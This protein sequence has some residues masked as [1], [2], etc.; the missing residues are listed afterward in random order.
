M[1]QN[2]TMTFR[3]FCLTLLQYYRNY[4]NNV[5]MRKIFTLLLLVF[6]ATPP[7]LHAADS[8]FKQ[9]SIYKRV[10]QNLALQNVDPTNPSSDYDINDTDGSIT[11]FLRMLFY[12]QEF[13]TDEGYYIWTTDYGLDQL[14]ANKLY[15]NNPELYG[16]YLRL[17]KGIDL[18]NT[19]LEN[20][21]T[22]TDSK[23]VQQRAEVRAMRALYFSYAMD[24][25]G[26]PPLTTSTTEVGKQVGRS[27][28]FDFI[29]NELKNVE[30]SVPAAKAYTSSDAN[31]GHVNQGVVWMLL[32]RL[33]LNAGVYT[34]TPHWA[35]AATYAKKVI[36]SGAYQLYTTATNGWSAYQ[37]LF[38]GDN[39][40]TKATQEMILPIY[41]QSKAVESWGAS[42][43]VAGPCQS[44][45]II[46]PDK[47]TK[48][49]GLSNGAWECVTAREPLVKRFFPDGKVPNVHACEM[50]TK[51]GDDRAIIEHSNGGY[52]YESDSQ[53]APYMVKYINFKTDGSAGSDKNFIDTDIPLMRYAEALMTYA[54][55]EFR[56]GNTQ[57]ALKYV[58]EIRT[59]ANA[60]T[61]TSLTLN[62]LYDE[63]SREFFYESRR[64]TDMIRFAKFAKAEFRNVF[65][66]P[67]KVQ[68]EQN[69]VQNAGYLAPT[70]KVAFH[71]PSFLNETITLDSITALRFSWTSVG[72]GAYDYVVKIDGSPN[73]SIELKK[74]TDTTLT[75]SARDLQR[76]IWSKY[77]Y[78]PAPKQIDQKVY[79]SALYNGKV[80]S[81]DSLTLHLVRSS[82]IDKH[83][84]FIAGKGIG[85]SKNDTSVK[86]VGSSSYPIIGTTEL[87]SDKRQNYMYFEQ[88]D[89]FKL[90]VPGHKDLQIRSLD[91]GIS[92]YYYNT[93]PWSHGMIYPCF[94]ISTAGWYKIGKLNEDTMTIAQVDDEVKEK[95]FK[96][97]KLTAGSQVYELKPMSNRTHETVYFR[98]VAIDKKTRVDIDA[99]TVALAHGVEL[100]PGTY[101]VFVNKQSLL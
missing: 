78:S 46:N 42:F 100:E 67:E 58:N 71:T 1:E 38:M 14:D 77:T 57:E 45:L 44:D 22:P 50:P 24:L 7:L 29:V 26:N 73:K 61:L 5:F 98:Q 6:L 36:D 101:D 21:S 53:N 94:T 18:C 76:A 64:R 99:D 8:G 13:T 62:D 59:R 84:W 33:Y 56:L 41:L 83:V 37:Q 88:G 65:P 10:Y 75:V 9:D 54:E 20:T 31:Y 32:A 28:L 52:N 11:G 27:A 87:Y 19:F 97:I 86:G 15:T 79:V 69:L 4:K 95:V 48:G 34:G 72:T 12:A 55:A 90:V 43:L 74:T 40:G 2:G 30:S 63:W 68:E 3:L 60:K 47:T 89:T 91:G 35:D 17:Y 39:G 96:S 92:N 81:T 80:A 93:Y 16:L 85:D 49:P 51:A 25:F 66:I 82:K 70:S 23:T